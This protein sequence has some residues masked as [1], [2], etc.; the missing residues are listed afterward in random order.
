MTN[1]FNITNTCINSGALLNIQDRNGYT[2]L[3]YCK[4]FISFIFSNRFIN[5]IFFKAIRLKNIDLVKLLVNAR[6]DLNVEINS[7]F[8][9]GNVKISLS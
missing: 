3:D 6:G 9:L 5:N 8:D 7:F 4:Y 2:P 1:N